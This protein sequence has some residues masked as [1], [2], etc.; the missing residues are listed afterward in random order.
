MSDA[1]TAVY[2]QEPG[3]LEQIEGS[4]ESFGLFIQNV[5]WKGR[6]QPQ[7]EEL[8]SEEV[9]KLVEK[10]DRLRNEP[11]ISFASTREAIDYLHSIVRRK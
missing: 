2:V 1:A 5:A 10:M 8:S 6:L 11:T 4:R 7:E 3:L 9:N